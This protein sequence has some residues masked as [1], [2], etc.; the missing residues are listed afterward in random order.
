MGVSLYHNHMFRIP[1]VQPTTRYVS[2]SIYFNR[3]LYM[4]QAVPP[5]I[6]RN[7]KCKYS[8]F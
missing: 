4:F 5:P 6:I 1:K 8:K 2:Q 3:T 7:S